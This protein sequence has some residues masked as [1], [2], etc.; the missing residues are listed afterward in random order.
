MTNLN[1][2]TKKEATMADKTRYEYQV[3]LMDYTVQKVTGQYMERHN[4]GVIGIVSDGATVAC[5]AKDAWQHVIRG[6]EVE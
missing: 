6:S 2:P 3:T 4:D 1:H 5:F